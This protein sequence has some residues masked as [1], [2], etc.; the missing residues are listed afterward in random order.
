MVGTV[1]L[2]SLSMEAIR[3]QSLTFK[4]P[5]N[6]LSIPRLMLAMNLMNS[7]T[8]QNATWAAHVSLR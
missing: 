8:I 4:R 7:D 6:G 3:A 1:A 5:I 2:S